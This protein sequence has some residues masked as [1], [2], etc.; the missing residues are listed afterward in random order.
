MP[1]TS[2][3]TYHS[4][5]NALRVLEAWV[6]VLAAHSLYTSSVLSPLLRLLPTRHSI[7][8]IVAALLLILSTDFARPSLGEW[9]FFRIETTPE[10]L[11]YTLPA[12]LRLKKGSAD[13]ENVE[14]ISRQEQSLT[15]ATSEHIFSIASCLSNYPELVQEL[16]AQFQQYHPA[17]S[18]EEELWDET[19]LDS[20]VL[21]KV[22]ALILAGQ[23]VRAMKTLREETELDALT[24]SQYVKQWS[25]K[26]GLTNSSPE[27]LDVV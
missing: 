27:A 14:I 24:A 2:I 20:A 26:Q 13:W 11:I 16:E 9:L 21:Q 19:T 4:F 3:Y 1:E 12:W 6:L 23:N 7:G 10:G 15:I 5:K 22:H 8:Y 18:D 25:E 17:S